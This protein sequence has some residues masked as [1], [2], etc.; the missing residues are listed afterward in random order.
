M[1]FCLVLTAVPGSAAEILDDPLADQFGGGSQTGTEGVR[2][3]PTYAQYSKDLPEMYVEK[4]VSLTAQLREEL[5][6]KEI[7]GKTAAHWSEDL[8]ELTWEFQVEEAGL[9]TLA[10]E[11]YLDGEKAYSAKRNLYVD[12]EVLFEEATGLAFHKRYVEEN[13]GRFNT[14]GDEI[15]GDNVPVNQ[16]MT[17]ELIDASGICLTPFRFYFEA[18]KHTVTLVFEEKEMYIGDLLVKSAEKLQDYQQVLAQYRA[19]GYKEAQGQE[20]TFEAESHVA[21]TNDV[22]IRRV[23][24]TDVTVT[25]YKYVEKLLNVYGGGRWDTGGQEITWRIE[26]PE[27]GLYKIA[28]RALTNLTDGLP[29]YRQIAIDGEVPFEELL[30]YRF[31]YNKEWYIETLHQGEDPYLFYFEEGVTHTITMTVMAAEYTDLIVSLH[32][33]SQKLTDYLLKV[34]ML[35]G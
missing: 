6:Q 23:N 26:V 10:L 18:G 15:R 34:T 4:A 32:Y 2:E 31:E 22:T 29:V 1:S 20:L 17:M 8:T 30:A 16:W 5:A 14:Y 12:G 21:W 24:S 19:N 9:Y 11:Y 3:Y 25:P 13:M 7:D 33:D 28:L 35:T 27:S